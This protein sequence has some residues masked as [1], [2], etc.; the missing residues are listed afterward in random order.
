MDCVNIIIDAAL[1]LVDDRVFLFGAVSFLNVL[2]GNVKYSPSS[3]STFR[4][5]GLSTSSTGSTSVKGVYKR[6]PKQQA[7]SRK[8]DISPTV[9]DFKTATANNGGSFNFSWMA[10]NDLIR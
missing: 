2:L 6:A 5:R 3:S 7:Y 9:L 10:L 1:R 8:S 4:S